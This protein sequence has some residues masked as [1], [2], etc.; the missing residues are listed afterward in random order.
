MAVP[1]RAPSR[2]ED[3]AVWQ[4]GPRCSADSRPPGRTETWGEQPGD[5]GLM[6]RSPKAFIFTQPPVDS[7][8]SGSK[9]SQE[10]YN[11]PFG[12]DELRFPL[13][14]VPVKNE[15]DS[16]LGLL[17]QPSFLVPREYD[18]QVLNRKYF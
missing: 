2:E 18:V 10:S 3:P 8:D 7:W 17:L 9:F 4:L 5:T 1:D 6:L 12:F 16:S 15:L 14:D 13:S 11:V